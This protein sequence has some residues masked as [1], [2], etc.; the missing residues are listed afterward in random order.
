MATAAATSKP[1][2]IIHTM[3][4]VG[5]LKRS[6]EFYQ[7]HFGMSVIRT[8]DVPEG[9]YTNVFIGYGEEES[10]PMIELTYNYGVETYENGTGFGHLAIGVPDIH[11][12]CETMRKEGV[13]IVREPGPVKFGTTVIAFVDDPDGYRIE[14]IQESK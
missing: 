1:A 11:A 9:K 14:L 5:D 6:I 10:D 12:T 13:T 2:R 3:I 4:R 7:T 8:I